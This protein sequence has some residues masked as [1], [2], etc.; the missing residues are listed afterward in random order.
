MGPRTGNR[1]VSKRQKR[2][3]LIAR[4]EGFFCPPL[5]AMPIPCQALRHARQSARR[6]RCRDLTAL[7]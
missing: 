7:A 5:I 4:K 3:T 6:G 2:G 1:A